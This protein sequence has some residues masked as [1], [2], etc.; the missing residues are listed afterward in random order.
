MK[1]RDAT[2][3]DLPEILKINQASVPHVGSV[4]MKQM[5]YFLKNADP[6]LVIQDDEAVA[7]FMI[8]LQSGLDYSSL[9]YSFFCNN[10]SS[11]DYVDRIAIAESYRGKKAGT[12]LYEYLFEHSEKNMVTCEVNIEPPNPVSMEFH[13]SLGFKK[14]AEMRVSKDSKKVAMLIKE[15][16]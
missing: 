12:A 10:Y 2:R 6:F 9:N 16:K 3:K 15:M 11:F 4:D 14:V 7:G 8:V 5:E 13:E 1:I